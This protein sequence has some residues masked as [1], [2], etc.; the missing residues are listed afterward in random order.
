LQQR[1]EEDLRCSE[2]E[3]Y[4]QQLVVAFQ[5]QQQQP[6]FSLSE[7]LQHFPT[8]QPGIVLDPIIA[9]DHHNHHSPPLLEAYSHNQSLPLQ[10]QQMCFLVEGELNH[11]TIKFESPSLRTPPLLLE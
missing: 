10:Q 6:Y 2:E 4:L 8:L 7:D 5:H 1:Q 11:N 9:L 3:E